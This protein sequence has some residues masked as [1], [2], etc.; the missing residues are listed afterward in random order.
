MIEYV[1]GF[2]YNGTHVVL[3]KKNRPEWQAGLYNGVGGHIEDFDGTPYDAMVRE[4]KEEAGVEVENWQH[5]LTLQGHSA[6]I[7]F[8][9]AN[10]EGGLSKVVTKTDEDV[11][12]VRFRDIDDGFFETV[13]N[14]KWIIPLMRQRDKYKQATVNFLGDS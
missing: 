3:I 8:Y 6:K 10:D 5:F 13:P 4:F 11:Y 9:A 12:A 14:L 7:Y 2:L 1:V